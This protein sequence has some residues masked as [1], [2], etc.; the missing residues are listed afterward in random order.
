M[1]EVAQLI[2]GEDSVFS[3]VLAKLSPKVGNREYDPLQKQL[4]SNRLVSVERDVRHPNHRVLHL[5]KRLQRLQHPRQ[6]SP[7]STYDRGAS[8]EKSRPALPAIL[9]DH[10]RRCTAGHVETFLLFIFLLRPS[11]MSSRRAQYASFIFWSSR[12]AKSS[13]DDEA[14]PKR[15]ANCSN[16]ASPSAIAPFILFVATTSASRTD[17][18]PEPSLASSSKRKRPPYTRRLSSEIVV[19]MESGHELQRSFE[20]VTASRNPGRQAS[21]LTSPKP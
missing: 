5:P 18:R 12:A 3:P 13:R 11:D 16:A 15:R 14:L 9:R 17:S 20:G 4:V 1:S 6:R 8:T 19:D 21:A 2:S 10:R 7:N